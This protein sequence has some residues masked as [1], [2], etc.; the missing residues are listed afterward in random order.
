M[1]KSYFKLSILV[2]L[3]VS[4]I[5]SS[6][7]KLKSKLVQNDLMNST[8]LLLSSNYSSKYGDYLINGKGM[9]LYMYVPD[10]NGT[11]VCYDSCEYR[12]PPLILQKGEI[13]T[14]ETLGAKINQNLVSTT[15]RTTNSTQITYNGMPLYFWFRDTVPG[16]IKGEAINDL[17]LWYLV[18]PS[19]KIIYG[20]E[21]M[22][23]TGI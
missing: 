8:S 22:N 13:L 1:N 14:N 20:N 23:S 16:D 11:S 4:T 3:L 10:S 5:F 17:G 19:G 21:T 6:K 2:I 9:T 18:N 12:W 15:I 7:N